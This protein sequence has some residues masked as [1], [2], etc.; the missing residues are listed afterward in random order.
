MRIGVLALQ[1]GFAEHI[2]ALN[3]LG[4]QSFEIRNINDLE[5][6][7]DGLII[8]GGESTVIGPLLKKTGLFNP[9]K[10]RIDGGL[11]V[12][13]TCAGMILL[14]EKIYDAPDAYFKS[15]RITVKRNAYG[16]Q[17]GSFHESGMFA[18]VGKIP[19]TF[20]RAPSIV[21]SGAGVRILAQVSGIGVAAESENILVT[22]FHPELTDDLNVLRYFL[23]KI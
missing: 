1:G 16:R 8:P 6:S 20:I 10:M 15:M 5:N 17:L 7:M 23:K 3:K 13:G 11:P 9:M 14:A 19:M 2:A 21:S 12:L 22:A 18:G 4:V